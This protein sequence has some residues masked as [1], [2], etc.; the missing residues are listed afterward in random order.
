MH[1][2]P[3]IAD[4]SPYTPG[5][6]VSALRRELGLDTIVKL[7][8]NE[9]PFG[10]FPA[11]RAALAEAL[12]GLN[13]YPERAAEL[14]E[15]LATRHGVA[16]E[17]IAQGNG[18]DG[19]IANIALA[20]L[21]PGDEVLMGW[22]SFVSYR[23][24]AVKMGAIPVQVPLAGG[25]YDLEALAGAVTPA[26]RL[27]YVCS[28]NNPT[29]GIVERDA[30]GA[31]LETVPDRVLVVIDAAYHEYVTDPG[32]VDAVAEHGHR[33]NVVVLRTFSKLFGLAGLRV[34]YAVAPAGVA[35][36]LAKVRGPFDVSELAN[37]AAVASLDDDDECAR[38]REVNRVERQRLVSALEERGLAVFPAAANFV[39]IDVGDGAALAARLEQEGVIVRPLAPFGAPGCVRVTVGLPE[40]DDAFLAALDRCLQ[41][42]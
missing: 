14:Q 34:G 25:S 32:H 3:E 31:F 23:L 5:K 7:A 42:A 16:P 6:P 12:P 15:R 39:C 22:P 24:A 33:P 9:G 30:L 10:P 20:Y 2:R 8:S 28:P 37:I 19:V 36:E 13:R 29:G 27:V 21:R 26:T 17:R 41:P 11:A 35:A 38:R 18:A 4:L 40:H 1:A